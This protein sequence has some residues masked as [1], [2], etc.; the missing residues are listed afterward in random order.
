MINLL[1]GLVSN[2]LPVAKMVYGEVQ[3][4]NC[5]PNKDGPIEEFLV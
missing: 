5:F 3:N 4:S 1:F 2:L